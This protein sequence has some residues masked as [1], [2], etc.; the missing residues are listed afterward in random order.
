MFVFLLIK[1][2]EPGPHGDRQ[3][4]WHWTRAQLFRIISHKIFDY[5]KSA[6]PLCIIWVYHLHL[7]TKLCHEF[8]WYEGILAYKKNNEIQFSTKYHYSFVNMLFS[9]H[10][11]FIKISPRK[12]TVLDAIFKLRQHIRILIGAFLSFLLTV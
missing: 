2:M 12:V 10:T 4:P 11:K 8:N 6:M 9:Y 5:L 3:V 7:R 1:E